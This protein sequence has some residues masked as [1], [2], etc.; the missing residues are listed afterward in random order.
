MDKI[1]DMIKSGSLKEVTDFRDEIDLSGFKLTLDL[2]RGVDPEKLMAKLYRLTPLEDSF[3]CNFNIL[4]D[5][6]PRQMGVLEIL[7]EWI[8]FRMGCVRRELT[9]ELGKKRDK[10]H[11]VEAMAKVL[12]DI[13]RRMLKAQSL[14]LGHFKEQLSKKG[15][16]R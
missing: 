9:Y 3:K 2:R 16:Y 13:D 10:L 5:S 6:V 14:T 4:I 11:L 1:A 12:L 8:I 15:N 7:K